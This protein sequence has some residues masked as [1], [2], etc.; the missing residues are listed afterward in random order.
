MKRIITL[1]LGNIWRW[2]K[3]KN[4]NALLNYIKNLDISGVE[5]TFATKDDLYSFKLSNKNKLWLENLNYVSIHAPFWLFKDSENVEEVF[6]QLNCIRKIYHQIGAKRVVIH[7]EPELIQSDI[8]NEYAIK[9]S[10]ENLPRKNNVPVSCLKKILRKYP[11]MDLCLDTSHAYSWSKYETGKLIQ[12]FKEK[13]SQI[14]FSGSY[15]R[16][17]HVSLRKVS[18]NFLFSI[19]P[20]K[21]LDVPVVIE[22]DMKIKSLKYLRDELEYTKRLF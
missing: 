4:R 15:R 8:L 18:K 5:L 10:I 21:H 12:T 20:I 17:Q 11:Q 22:E 13:I 19:Q 14:H 7:P 9:F 1:A 6:H 2:N 16:K 3:S